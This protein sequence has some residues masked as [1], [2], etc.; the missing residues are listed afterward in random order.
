MRDSIAEAALSL[1]SSIGPPPV[2]EPR[3]PYKLTAQFASLIVLLLDCIG[4]G[5]NRC[6]F[7]KFFTAFL[8]EFSF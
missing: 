1:C 2:L 5:S 8:N 4:R 3:Y 7:L 6:W